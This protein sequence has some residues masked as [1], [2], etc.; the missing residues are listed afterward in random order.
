MNIEYKGVVFGCSKDPFMITEA[1]GQ[2]MGWSPD[3]PDSVCL[4]GENLV[5]IL[6]IIKD[7]LDSDELKALVAAHP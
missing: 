3:W 2:H 4:D 6:G 7:F 5:S 1:N